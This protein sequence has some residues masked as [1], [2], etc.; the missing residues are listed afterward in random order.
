MVKVKDGHTRISF[1]FR[2]AEGAMEFWESF[3]DANPDYA[4]VG[5]VLED[6]LHARPSGGNN[7]LVRNQD[8]PSLFGGNGRPVT[9]SITTSSNF[10]ILTETEHA[11]DKG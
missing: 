5:L 8:P 11:P 4:S 9:H 3:K 7:W 10:E 6:S 1:D 2:T